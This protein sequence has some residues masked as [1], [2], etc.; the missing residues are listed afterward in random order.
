MAAKTEAEAIGDAPPS[1]TQYINLA[2][3]AYASGSVPL[4]PALETDLQLAPLTYGGKVVS[5]LDTATGFYGEAFVTTGTASPQVIIAFQGTNPNA[6]SA[7][8]TVAQL[9]DDAAIYAGARAPSYGTALAFTRLAIR[10]AARLG[11]ASSDD[12]LT[13]HSLGA[14]DAEFVASRTGLAGTTFGTPGIVVGAHARASRLTDYVEEGDPVGNYASDAPDTLGGIVRSPSIR[15]YG[16][17]QL[18]GSPAHAG[19]LTAA[20]DAYGSGGILGK[21]AAVGLLAAAADQ[22]HP[23]VT[24]AQDLG[25]LLYPED[26]SA[27]SDAGFFGSATSAEVASAAGAV[28][29][30][31]E[32]T[33]IRT[34]RGDVAIERLAVGDEVVTASGARRP[35][36]W[37]GHRRIDCARHPRPDEVRPVRIAAHAFGADKPAR[38]LVVS[39]GHAIAVD[40]L[41]AA[42][43]PAGALVDGASVTRDACGAVTYWHLEL[44]AHDIVLAENL[45]AESFLAFGATGFFARDGIVALDA[46]PDA[47][48]VHARFCRPFHGEGPVVEAV[49]ARLAAIR[50]AKAA[51]LVQRSADAA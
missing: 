38:D 6:P 35:I 1:L 48:V 25:L 45:P 26:Y 21:A 13:G 36:R 2:D 40:V 37:L 20:R 9:A 22:Y 49:R 46:Q 5:R 47:A 10:D 4:N 11:I 19:L 16:T 30:Y 24:Y 41:G 31:A 17:T 23:L 43:V 50:V 39:P 7:A 32:G 14:A 15:H 42:L 28:N 29:C 44:E 3:Y 51:G 34:P 27:G 12:F 33:L 8:Y 18:T